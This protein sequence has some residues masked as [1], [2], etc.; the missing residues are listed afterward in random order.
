MGHQDPLVKLVLQGQQERLV[1]RGSQESKAYLGTL[2]L[3]DRKDKQDLKDQGD[4][5]DQMVR[6]VVLGNKENKALLEPQ[7]PKALQ[8]NRDQLV[9]QVSV[10]QLEIQGV[11][12]LQD[13]LVA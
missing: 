1:L 9:L 4:Q 12:V 8:V 2:G 13:L 11:L 3:L 5:L 10:D 7:V 6:M